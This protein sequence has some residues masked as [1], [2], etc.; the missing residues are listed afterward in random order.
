MTRS[1]SSCSA[2]SSSWSA[3]SWRGSCGPPAYGARGIAGEKGHL[4]AELLA[5]I[6]VATKRFR[7]LASPMTTRFAA[8]FIYADGCSLRLDHLLGDPPP[9]QAVLRTEAQFKEGIFRFR[10]RVVRRD[11]SEAWYEEAGRIPAGDEP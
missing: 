6:D 2:D 7:R 4:L 1:R 5:T 3:S 10:L 8:I 9:R 11:C